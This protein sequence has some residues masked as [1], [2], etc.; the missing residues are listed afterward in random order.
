[1]G[2]TQNVSDKKMALANDLRKQVAAQLKTDKELY[3]C[4]SGGQMM[5]EI[6][7]L[8]LSFNYYKDIDIPEA[9]KLLVESVNTFT[10]TINNEKRIHPYLNNYPFTPKNIELRIFIYKKGTVDINPGHLSIVSIIGGNLRYKM[11]DPEN[12]FSLI[13]IHSESYEEAV[14]QLEESDRLAQTGER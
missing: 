10:Q 8:A 3:P 11:N 4:G 12:K 1:M 2:C 6:K 5:D 13:T 7:M 14:R 9:R